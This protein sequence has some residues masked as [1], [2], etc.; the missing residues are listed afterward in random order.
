MKIYFFV[1]FLASWA[2]FLWGQA[3]AKKLLTQ[4][5]YLQFTEMST[6]ILSP[7][8]KWSS[9]KLFS[10][11]T[12]DTVKVVATDGSKVYAFPESYGTNFSNNA[13]WFAFK[14][15]QKGF[16]LLNLNTG[17]LKYNLDGTSYKFSEDGNLLG[18]KTTGHHGNSPKGLLLYNLSK[19]DSL[20]LEG[21][22]AYNFSPNSKYLLYIASRNEDV[23]VNL[24]NLSDGS[25][26]VLNERAESYSKLLWSD[27]GE[28]FFFVQN[29]SILYYGNAQY[30]TKLISQSLKAPLF[31]NMHIGF[32]APFFS[33]DGRRVFFYMHRKII[34][35]NANDT[36]PSVQTWKGSDKWVYPRK[37]IESTP[38]NWQMLCSWNPIK[39][40]LQQIA[41][42]EKPQIVLTSN[43]KYAL[44]F[45]IMDYE[46]LYLQHP[47]VD[48]YL[49]N[50]ESG[51]E[52]LLIAKQQ[53]GGGYIQ[54]SPS[55]N[56]IAYFNGNDWINY[57][58]S[59]Q[60]FT[61]LT[62][63]FTTVLYKEKHDRP[64][65]LIPYGMVGWTQDDTGVLI[66]DAYDI[67]HISI[68][69]KSYKRLTR[70]RETKTVYRLP[71]NLLK[72]YPPIRT[73]EFY[74][75]EIDLSKELIMSIKGTDKSSGYAV[76]SP[77]GMIKNF[78]I[79]A[80]KS[81]GLQKAKD[82]K[83]YVFITESPNTPPQLYYIKDSEK[84]TKL[85][86]QSNPQYKNFVNG[87]RE[88]ITYKAGVWKNLNGIL[89]YPD[90]YQPD[91]KYPMIV[92]IYEVQSHNF[93]NYC[94]P[95]LYTR[96]GY[97]PESLTAEGY[98][99]FEPDIKY[100]IGNP[101]ISAVECVT[102]AV[103]KVLSLNVVD[104]DR[105]GLLGHS[106]GGYETAFIVGQTNIFKA[107]V[108][109]APV[110]NMLSYYLSINSDDGLPQIWR[111]EHQQWRMGK[112][113]FDDPEAY[114]QNSPIEHIKNINTPLMIWEG[115]QDRNIHWFQSVEM[116]L[117][118]RR[119][120]KVVTFYVYPGEAHDIDISENQR[121]LSQKIIEWFDT[122]LK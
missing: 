99:V 101:G 107:A 78:G 72:G 34:P 46:P 119:L 42:P 103:N 55:G 113:Y 73:P 49:L 108:A 50:L 93:Y 59:K 87:K 69:G 11:E 18:L 65:P 12:V 117:A 39:R 26:I 64:E 51:E 1:Y 41:S 70:G 52:K 88:L 110:T 71:T 47:K 105:V 66:Y 118:L 92:K 53:T 112:S 17:K 122:Y 84:S 22:S 75:Y 43:Q 102:A 94:F 25:S 33:K 44:R 74:S 95:S 67:W 61:N 3:P 27:S 91:R 35:V 24:L 15:Q 104:K 97:N 98:F 36:L 63:R 21:V 58:I 7:N 83:A 57:S 76:L 60:Q 96:D 37:I 32:L 23:S 5:D 20:F 82:G 89:Y 79:F 28:Q 2:C 106:Y 100:R 120:N 114:R 4:N 29:D 62:K 115:D 54:L 111:M 30:P 31:K 40:K 68:N 81:H 48:I 10:Q 116:Y 80:S 77:N 6:P 45:N 86:Y 16:G 56:N 109:G 13:Q 85:I 19:N 9:F 38:E 8:G 90:N 14:N 121:D